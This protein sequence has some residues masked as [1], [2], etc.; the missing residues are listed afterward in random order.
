MEKPS[1]VEYALMRKKAANLD[2]L[3][4]LDDSDLVPC[5]NCLDW[6]PLSLLEQRDQEFYCLHCLVMMSRYD[7]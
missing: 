5:K 3:V 1:L 7:A 6:L 2:R 4:Q